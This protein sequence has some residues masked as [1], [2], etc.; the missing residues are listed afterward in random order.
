ML[1]WVV[2]ASCSLYLVFPVFVV[3]PVSFSSAKYLQFPPPG[4]SLQWYENYFARPGLGP[5]HSRS[6]SA[7][8]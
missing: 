6:A 5:G 1:L 7:W 2:V 8:R 4:W 3:A